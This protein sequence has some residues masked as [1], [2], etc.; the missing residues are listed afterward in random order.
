MSTFGTSDQTP[1]VVGK[2]LE[3]YVGQKVRLV[4]S[5]MG[6]QNDDVALKSPD[7]MAITV[8]SRPSS[9]YQSKVVE[10]VG[11][12]KSRDTIEEVEFSN[13]GD[14]L[15][16]RLRWISLL[17]F[18]FFFW[19]ARATTT[20]VS[21]FSGDGPAGGRYG[22]ILQNVRACQWRVPRSLPVKKAFPVHS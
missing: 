9:Q 5:V 11:V 16:K 15:G 18:L 7:G 20:V 13:F 6:P 4:G 12:V 19:R 1:R 3:Q 22:H 10:V 17:F 8:V 21:Y 14:S 2:Q